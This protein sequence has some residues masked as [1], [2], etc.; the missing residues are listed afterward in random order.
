VSKMSA[1]FS[2]TPQS[3]R[4]PMMIPTAGSAISVSLSAA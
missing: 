2:I 3:E 1:A 4:E